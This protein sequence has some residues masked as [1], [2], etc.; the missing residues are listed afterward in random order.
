MIL[1]IKRVK[2]DAANEE[3]RNAYFNFLNT[4]RWCKHFEVEY[5]YV[6][7]PAQLAQQTLRFYRD[8]ETRLV[9]TA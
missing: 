6:E 3:H 1:N 9:S 8:R 7:L 4:G 5:P 2:Y